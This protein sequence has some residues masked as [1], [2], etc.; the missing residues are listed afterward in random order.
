MRG[1]SAWLGSWRW[2]EHGA[3]P[4]HYPPAG[5]RNGEP[6]GHL[7]GGGASP[8]N[9]AVPEKQF[10]NVTL[11]EVFDLEAGRRRGSFLT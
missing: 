7:D 2:Q 6:S 8:L 10:E 9:L 3:A 4:R 5:G 11:G 1:R